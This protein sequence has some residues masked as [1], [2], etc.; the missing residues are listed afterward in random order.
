[1]KRV[2]LPWLLMCIV[3]CAPYG[4]WPFST[5]EQRDCLLD[6][7]GMTV[8]QIVQKRGRALKKRHYNPAAYNSWFTPPS[9][10]TGIAYFP[11]PAGEEIHFLNGVAIQVRFVKFPWDGYDTWQRHEL[12][13]K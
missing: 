1:M 7:P 2:I 4:P 13:W 8:D 6:Y 3:G 11:N 12:L 5:Q 9:D 10:F